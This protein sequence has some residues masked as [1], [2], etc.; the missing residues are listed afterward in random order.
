VTLSA[1]QGRVGRTVREKVAV[2]DAGDAR[3]NGVSFM[4][5]AVLGAGGG[6]LAVAYE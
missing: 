6:R 2:D 4:N 5:V 1:G 3:T